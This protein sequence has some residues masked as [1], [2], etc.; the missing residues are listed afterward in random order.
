MV[1]NYFNTELS[2][3]VFDANSLEEWKSIVDELGLSNQDEL[4]KGKLSPIPFPFVNENMKRVYETLC[5]QRVNFRSYKKTTIPLDVLKQIKHCVKDSHFQ[6]IEIWYDDK[7]PDPVVVGVTGNYSSYDVEGYYPSIAEYES[8][9]KAQGKEPNKN[10]R[11]YNEEYYLIARWGD[12]LRD[13]ATLKKMAIE[14]FIDNEAGELKR[15]IE[16]LGIKLQLIHENTVSY[17]NG[18]LRKSQ[19]TQ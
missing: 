17:F 19:V 18:N 14:R 16:E 7:G 10:P 3:I 12:E 2:D 5:P 9:A 13:F 15:K 1:E 8:A 6:E 11:L 4:A